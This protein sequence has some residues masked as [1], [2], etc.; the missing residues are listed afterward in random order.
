MPALLLREEL[1]GLG[2]IWRLLDEEP[3]GLNREYG[4]LCIIAESGERMAYNGVITVLESKAKRMSTGKV[5]GI[6]N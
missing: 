2:S 3:W 5:T 4:F 6:P 1:A